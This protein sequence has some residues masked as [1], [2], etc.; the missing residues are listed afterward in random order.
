MK[1]KHV[2]RTKRMPPRVALKF[3]GSSSN[4]VEVPTSV[5]FSVSLFGLTVALWVRP[6]T[7]EFVN[8]EPRGGD[9]SCQYVHWVGK[10]ETGQQE[11]TFRMYRDDATVCSGVPSDRSKR[12]S[13]YVFAPDGHRG[14]GSYF[15][16]DIQP[17]C[18]IHVVGVV[19]PSKLSVAIY[20]NGV[21]RH[22]DS[23]ASLQLAAG[24]ANL[25]IATRD[26]V[27]SFFQGALAEIQIWNVVLNDRQIDELYQFG[28]VPVDPVAQYSLDEGSG[29]VVRDVVG[30]HDD[31]TVIGGTW[32]FGLYPVD[33]S[34][35]GKSGGGC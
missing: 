9:P 25:R 19:D 5:D 18:W 2:R 1:E 3:D 6:D 32:D 15:Q 28:L 33:E 17:A 14:C 24:S 26:A 22:R 13:F 20:K 35:I 8:T 31:G 30:T 7:F 11:W 10:G 4:F 21:F 12:I 23:Y 34:P 29:S 27:N 16:D